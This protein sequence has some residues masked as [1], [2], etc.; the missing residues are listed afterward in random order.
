MVHTPNMT[1]YE[2]TRAT[3]KWGD[4]PT[5]Y[6]EPWRE[7]CWY[8]SATYTIRDR[9]DTASCDEGGRNHAGTYRS[10]VY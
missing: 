9:R 5:F 6:K 10:G 1:D 8:A 7:G 2:Q 3:F 4:L